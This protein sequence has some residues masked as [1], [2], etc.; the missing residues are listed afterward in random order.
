MTALPREGLEPRDRLVAALDVADVDMARRLVDTLGSACGFYKIGYRLAYAG[1]LDLADELLG[2]G[3]R[4]FLD[5]KL[6]DIDNT[7]REGVA[8]LSAR[9][10]TCLTVHAYPHAMRAAVAGRA[11]GTAILAVTVLTSLGDAGLREAG[12]AVSAREL[13][14][15]RAAEAAGIGV[16][17]VVCSGQEAALVR[18]TAP[19]LVIVTPGI[20]PGGA[21]RGDQTRAVTPAAAIRA[22][23]DY[24]VVGRPI[25]HAP[26]PRGAAEAIAREIAAA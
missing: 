26:D 24:L 23:A 3:H 4:V 25:T 15:R 12:Y 5:L 18:E 19:D 13:V 22:G 8:A 16:D 17:G 7:V 11:G 10:A 21:A 20:R 9:G 6:L 1:G 14:A 2:A